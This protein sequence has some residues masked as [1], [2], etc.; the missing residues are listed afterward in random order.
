MAAEH[1]R[2]A[3]LVFGWSFYRQG[4]S[5]GTSSAN[6]FVDEAL[7]GLGNQIRTSERHGRGKTAS[8]VRSV[9]ILLVPA[10]PSLVWLVKS[11]RAG[12]GMWFARNPAP[13]VMAVPE[14]APELAVG[15]QGIDA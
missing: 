6:E 4:S 13:L 7:A 12:L 3:Q 2:S 10:N 9:R 1:Y 11:G 15:I 8:R 14:A 5:G